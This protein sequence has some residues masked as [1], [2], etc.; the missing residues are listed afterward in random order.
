MTAWKRRAALVVGVVAAALQGAPVDGDHL[1]AAHV[2]ALAARDGRAPGEAVGGHRPAHGGVRRGD[3]RVGQEPA[4]RQ[5]GEDVPPG[6]RGA[7][8]DVPAALVA[9]GLVHRIEAGGPEEDHDV[10]VERAPVHRLA[11]AA[12]GDPVLLLGAGERAQEP[13]ERGQVA[14]PVRAGRWRGGSGRSSTRRSPSPSRRGLLDR[15]SAVAARIAHAGPTSPRAPTARSRWPRRARRGRA[16]RSA[17]HDGLAPPAPPR[18]EGVHLQRLRDRVDQPGV[19]HAFAGMNRH[20][21]R[22]GRRLPSICSGSSHTQSGRDGEVRLLGQG[23]QPFAAA[24]RRGPAR[25]LRS[26]PGPRRVGGSGA[27]G[28]SRIHQPP[29]PPRLGPFAPNMLPSSTSELRARVRRASGA[30]RGTTCAAARRSAPRPCSAARP[31][32]SAYVARRRTSAG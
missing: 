11:A 25:R 14:R 4:L 10:G 26:S 23:S 7:D 9:G 21:S 22:G 15:V 2:R 1:E 20:S 8:G 3:H 24:S 12:E 19:A 16:G 31:P 13:G 28:S 5:R 29:G 32:R 30:E 18:S 27:P 17:V 6:R